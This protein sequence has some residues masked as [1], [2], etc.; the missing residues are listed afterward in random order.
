MQFL[1]PATCLGRTIIG[2]NRPCF[3]CIALLI[4][5]GGALTPRDRLSLRDN[6]SLPKGAGQTNSLEVQTVANKAT[7]FVNGTKIAEFNREAAGRAA[8]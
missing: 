5:G 4:Q 2:T 3:E 1:K 6:G 8:V 7:L